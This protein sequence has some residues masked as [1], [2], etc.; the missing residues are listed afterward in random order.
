MQHRETDAL[1][2]K[3]KQMQLSCMHACMHASMYVK[4]AARTFKGQLPPLLQRVSPERSRKQTKLC[5]HPKPAH[6][7]THA[8][9]QKPHYSALIPHSV[10]PQRL[11]AVLTVPLAIYIYSIY[12]YIYILYIYT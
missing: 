3:T 2:Q 8:C 4:T 11:F 1:A 12:M 9:K 7:C 6:A 5:I 10:S